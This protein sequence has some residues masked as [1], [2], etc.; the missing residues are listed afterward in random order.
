[1]KEKHNEFE[2]EMKEKHKKFE[3]DM[4]K[5]RKEYE[6][7]MKDKQHEMEMV[8][9]EAELE[10]SKALATHLGIEESKMLAKRQ[11]KELLRRERMF[12]SEKVARDDII[13]L[14]EVER[15]K[16]IIIHKHAKDVTN[17][18]KDTE[19]LNTRLSEM[20][21]NFDEERAKYHNNL[22]KVKATGQLKTHKVHQEKILH[23]ELV[24]KEVEK[25]KEGLQTIS[26]LHKWVD[27][28]HVELKEAKSAAK[29]VMRGKLKSDSAADKRLHLLTALKVE[30]AEV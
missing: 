11:G 8:I 23:R 30:L 14:K 25:R 9:I 15:E 21:S 3:L 18:E 7:G 19:R 20:E 6:V 22:N 2:L 29:L 26:D 16:K 24:A 17:H 4:K 27:E 5:K 13:R 1:M 10:S 12:W 28:I